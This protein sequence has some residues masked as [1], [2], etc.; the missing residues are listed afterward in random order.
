MCSFYLIFVV[1]I[2]IY[3]IQT[4]HNAGLGILYGKLH[5]SYVWN[6]RPPRKPRKLEEEKDNSFVGLREVNWSQ[7]A[8][9]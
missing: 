2:Y 7:N 9:V 8:I 3:F 1:G 5:F 6:G 4:L